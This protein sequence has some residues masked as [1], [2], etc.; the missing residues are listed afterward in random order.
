MALATM[1]PEFY[2][3]CRNCGQWRRQHVGS[4]RKCLFQASRF[5]PKCPMDFTAAEREST[6]ERLERLDRQLVERVRKKA[7]DLEQAIGKINEAARAGCQHINDE[8]M[9]LL[10][11]HAPR[12]GEKYHVICSL[13]EEDW[14]E[15]EEG[16]KLHPEGVARPGE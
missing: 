8:G 10:E 1:T 11:R 15:D 14:Y 4:E 2:F 5:A 3:P 6:I 9:G 16:N 13:C 12:E 7:D